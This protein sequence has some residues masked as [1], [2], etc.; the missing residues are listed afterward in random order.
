[1]NENKMID[2]TPKQRLVIVEKIDFRVSHKIKR[3]IFRIKVGDELP[4]EVSPAEF[5]KLMKIAKSFVNQ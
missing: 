2:N 4:L 5:K 3:D 1:M